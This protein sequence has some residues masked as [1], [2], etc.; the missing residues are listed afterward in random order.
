MRAT[1]G[2]FLLTAAALIG[3]VAWKQDAT[4]KERLAEMEAQVT[5]HIASKAKAL[6]DNH[7]LALTGLVA[8][9]ALGDVQSLVQRA[10]EKTAIS[11]TGCSWIATANPGHPLTTSC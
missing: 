4:E 5:A 9:N 1:L 10:V 11:S 7:A 3:V 2:V 8:D 6:V